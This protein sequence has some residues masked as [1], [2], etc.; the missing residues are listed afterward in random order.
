MLTITVA[1]D[2]SGNF[3]SI[4]EAVMAVPYD[5]PARI[6]IGPGTY[7]EK[8]VCEK[9]QITLKGAGMEQTPPGVERRR[10]AAP[11]GR[12]PHPYLP[13]LD[14]IFQRGRSDGRGYD[15]PER[16]RS[17][18]PG[19]PGHCGLCGQ[20]AGGFPPCAAAGQPGYPVLCAPARE[21]AGEGRL[22]GAPG[23]CAAAAQR[24]VLPGVRHRRGHRFHLWR[25]RRSV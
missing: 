6:L 17:R 5:T 24:P 9:Q 22:F 12:P 4:G 25:G 2:G 18:R 10:Q 13:Q 1:Q 19:G 11:P 15:H 7:R 8:L 20:P 16:R 3:A 14:R 21:R 23:V